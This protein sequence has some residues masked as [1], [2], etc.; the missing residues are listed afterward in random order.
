MRSKQ[1]RGRW[2]VVRMVGSAVDREA[3]LLRSDDVDAESPDRAG[4]W[5][6]AVPHRTGDQVRHLC[7]D[8]HPLVKPT[9]IPRVE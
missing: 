6:E 8:A 3:V 1:H 9:A 4:M 2:T 5:L 7:H